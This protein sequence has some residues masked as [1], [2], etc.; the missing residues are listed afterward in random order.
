MTESES[1]QHDEREAISYFL[2][3]KKN[4]ELQRQQWERKWDQAEAAVYMRDNYLD[5]VYAGR[6]V[7]NSPIMKWKVKGITARI[8]KVLFNV[9]PFGRIT[10]KKLKEV[11]QTTVDLWNK[12]IFECQLDRIDFKEN[13]KMFSKDK[14]IYGTAVAKITQEYET[15]EVDFFEDGGEPEEVTVK[16]DTYFRPV[17]LK[18]FY[19]DSSKYNINDSQACI[20][21]TKISWSELKKN[22]K[23]KE[24]QTFELIDRETGQDL[25]TEEEQVEVGVYHN[26]ELLEGN[27][28]NLTEE[29]EEYL[30]RMGFNIT[31]TQIFQKGLREKDKTGYVTIDECYGK[32]VIDGEEKEVICVIANGQVVIRLEETPFKHRRYIR[33]F[34]VGRYEPVPNR[35]Y[36]ESNVI[37]GLNLLQELNAS[38][39]MNIDAGTQSIFPMNYIDMTKEVN[40]DG[41]WRPN[42]IVKGLGPNGMTPIL[43]PFLGNI[44]LETSQLI[45]RDLDQL[46]SL[47]P[48]QEGTTDKSQIPATARATIAVIAQNDLPLN[49]I[50]DNAIEEELKP[51]IEMLLERDLVFKDVEDL[52][53]VWEERDIVAAGITDETS[54]RDLFFDFNVKILGSLELSNEIAQ[55]NAWVNFIAL[56]EKNPEM[57]RRLNYTEVFDR[58]LKSFG[59][60]DDSEGIFFDEVEVA[61][62]AQEQQQAAMQEQQQLEMDRQKQRAESVQDYRAKVDTDV[63]GKLA[64]MQGEVALEVATGKKIM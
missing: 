16:D 8:N 26:L 35:L 51:F 50:I 4:Y 59:I 11:K 47:S 31:Q 52:L 49:D 17:L 22:E 19:S 41:N 61:K 45:Q 55:Q 3:L 13:Y 25:G 20:H 56:T 36:G 2:G 18:E 40:W 63:E 21:S 60:K 43:N 15:K 44:K 10:D 38:R 64:E 28:K 62:T 23:R 7:I 29:Q 54:M 14:C 24:T 12:Y 53:S 48:V 30:E 46:W 9:S 5:K 33:P 6:A 34:I 39:A 57:V 37:A 1:R 32:F 42:G 27:G 58:Y